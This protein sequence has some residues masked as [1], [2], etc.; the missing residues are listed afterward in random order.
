MACHEIGIATVRIGHRLEGE[1]R[2]SCKMTLLRK[3]NT[4]ITDQRFQLTTV[5]TVHGD[6]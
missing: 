3:K 5:T 1:P 4:V 6:L 2:Q